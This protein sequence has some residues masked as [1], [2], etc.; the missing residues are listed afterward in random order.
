MGYAKDYY[1]GIIRD[2]ES[3]IPKDGHPLVKESIKNSARRLYDL[4][5]YNTSLYM[6]MLLDEFLT[7]MENRHKSQNEDVWNVTKDMLMSEF[8]IYL[9]WGL[10]AVDHFDDE[11]GEEA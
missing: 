2:L 8:Q 5:G 6:P 10:D 9:K 11:K 3:V 1:E 4:V 7:M